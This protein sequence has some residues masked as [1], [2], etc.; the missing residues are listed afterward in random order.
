MCTPALAEFPR[1]YSV[2]VLMPKKFFKD[3]VLSTL[4]EHTLLLSFQGHPTGWE[5]LLCAIVISVSLA[6]LSPCMLSCVYI[7]QKVLL[8]L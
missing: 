7:V 3:F 5:L 6:K 1:K 4:Y 2:L 8:R